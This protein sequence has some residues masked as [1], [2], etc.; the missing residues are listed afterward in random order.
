M[1]RDLGLR[2]RGFVFARHDITCRLNQFLG[3][4]L[5]LVSLFFSSFLPSYQPID[6]PTS[7]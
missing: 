4:F 1:A 7:H 6:T 5:L 2:K 3:F